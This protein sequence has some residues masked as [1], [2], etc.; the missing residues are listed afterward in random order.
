MAIR[1]AESLTIPVL[2]NLLSDN[3][4]APL[5]SRARKADYVIAVVKVSKDKLG[6]WDKVVALLKKQGGK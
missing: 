3:G 6:D 1:C 4:G 2:K 5:T